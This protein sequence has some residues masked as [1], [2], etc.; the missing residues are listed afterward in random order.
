VNCT[1]VKTGLVA[2][3]AAGV[4]DVRHPPWSVVVPFVVEG[5]VVREDV[6][7]V[8]EVVRLV[9]D[10]LDVP[11]RRV[12]PL[13]CG[14]EVTESSPPREPPVPHAASRHAPTRARLASDPAHHPRSWPLG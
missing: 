12:A 13:R 6:L 7:V 5:V 2:L 1:S 11:V 4:E 3:A 8:E 14:R 10:V 9:F